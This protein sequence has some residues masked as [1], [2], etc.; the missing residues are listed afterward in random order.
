YLLGIS[1]LTV[2]SSS[3]SVSAEIPSRHQSL[4]PLLAKETAFF[5]RLTIQPN[6]LQGKGLEKRQEAENTSLV[7]S[8]ISANQPTTI[9]GKRAGITQPTLIQT[10]QDVDGS[11]PSHQ[12][13]SAWV[14]PAQPKYDPLFGFASVKPK[15]ESFNLTRAEETNPNP[16]NT[17]HINQS[18]THTQIGQLKQVSSDR[19]LNGVKIAIAPKPLPQPI[20]LNSLPQTIPVNPLQEQLIPPNQ[21]VQPAA[22]I[23]G[24]A[25]TSAQL[26]IA[27]PTQP[28]VQPA[29]SLFLSR[30]PSA[31]L[32]QA[33]LDPRRGRMGTPNY[34]GIGGNLGLSD[35]SS[36]TSLGDGGFVVNSKIRLN[37]KLSLRPAAIFGNDATFLI[38]LTYDFTI[39]TA[40]PF[41]PVRFSPFLGGGLAISTDD[42]DSIGFLLTG[43]IDVP[44]SRAFVANASLNIGFI[45]DETDF[46][47]II[48]IGYT[49]PKR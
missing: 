31:I 14:K 29:D 11:L 8:E 41:E 13:N 46:G 43:G 39:P 40:D 2:T 35:N 49:F 18:Q 42:N 15:Q 12:V 17:T 19:T 24:T 22:P 28:S 4:E 1:A 30:Q 45:E 21:V 23:P 7:T 33:D 9:S 27:P 10:P 26:L 36:G 3:L 38:P 16:D 44:I 34:L 6:R 5:A 48:G 47:I 25:A 20:A 37:S 32:A